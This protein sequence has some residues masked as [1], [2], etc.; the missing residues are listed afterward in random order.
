VY[1]ELRQAGSSNANL[2]GFLLIAG[3]ARVLV[4][5]WDT[6]VRVLEQIIGYRPRWGYVLTPVPFWPN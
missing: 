6:S 1:E 2:D 3:E 4:G 5:F